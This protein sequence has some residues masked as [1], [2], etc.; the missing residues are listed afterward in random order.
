MA[1]ELAK[2]SIKRYEGL[3]LKAY[4][5]PAGKWTIGWGTTGGVTRGMVITEAQ[6]QTY[7][8]VFVAHLA[9]QIKAVVRR[10]TKP[11]ELDA[12]I[13]LAY[14]IGFPAFR[15]STVLRRHNAY[16]GKD[17]MDK[18]FLMWVKSTVDGKKVTLKGLVTRRW[19]EAQIYSSG[20]LL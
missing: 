6:A 20:E 15:D 2:K 14:N 19:S 3:R 18:A 4:L 16:A 8:D 5:C 12:F 17:E 13:S 11:H 7:L 10:D 9:D 1:Y